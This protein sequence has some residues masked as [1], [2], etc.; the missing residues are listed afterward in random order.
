MPALEIGMSQHDR[1]V[2][3]NEKGLQRHKHVVHI[4]NMFDHFF[5][6]GITEGLV[7]LSLVDGLLQRWGRSNHPGVP[8]QTCPLPLFVAQVLSVAAQALSHVCGA[9]QRAECRWRALQ[10]VP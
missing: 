3:G 2:P 8:M 7:R 5:Y 9:S 4:P 6:H 1:C 10:Q